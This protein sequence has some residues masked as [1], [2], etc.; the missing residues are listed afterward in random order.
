[1]RP[2][3]AV[4]R[5]FVALWPPD[6]VRDALFG[7]ARACHA[8]CRGR[9]VRRENLHV[10]LAFLGETARA[11]LPELA[12]ILAQVRAPQ[13]DLVLDRLG[14]WPH[15]RIVYGGTSAMPPALVALAA[16]LGSRLRD[17]GFRGDDRPYVAHVT[18]LRHAQRG[19]EDT[20]VEP[21]AWHVG[22]L[23]L[24]ESLRTDSGQ[25]YRPLQRWTLGN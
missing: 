4:L 10:T 9:L 25:D 19:P 7:W 2:D 13:F 6:D 5:L 17:A 8:T 15:N 18:L 22:E 3:P 23:V 11:R 16:G 20:R 14:Y 21:V 1:M 12:A 24:V